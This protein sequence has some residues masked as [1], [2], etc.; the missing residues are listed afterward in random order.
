MRGPK[1]SLDSTKS[2]AASTSARRIHRPL[3]H[4]E[5]S[6]NL[7]EHCADIYHRCDDANRRL[8]NQAFFTKIYNDEDNDLHV[9]YARPFEMLL[10]PDVQAD[11]LTWAADTDKAR[12][13]TDK[14]SPVESSSLVRMVPPR[15]FEPR[16]QG[17]KVPCSTN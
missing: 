12:T 11:A 7:L 4:L 16:T 8:C 13:P 3:T 15:G 10:E 17:L 6:L 5:D 1:S 2:P 9:D 14:D